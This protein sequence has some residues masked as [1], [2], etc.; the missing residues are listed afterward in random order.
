[1]LFAVSSVGLAELLVKAKSPV[2]VQGPTVLQ[3]PPTI[4]PAGP[5]AA[6]PGNQTVTQGGTS[7]GSSGGSTG[8]SSGGTAGGSGG[9]GGTSGGAGGTTGGSG[10]S[11]GGSGGTTGGTGGTSGGSGGTPQPPSGY[12]YLAAVS[13]V[14]GSSAYFN[15]PSGGSCILVDYNGT[16]RAF[17]A[18]CTHAGCVC[19]FT[20]STLYCPCHGANFSATNGAVINGP[21]NT[22]VAEYGIQIVNSNFYV[23]S[24]RIN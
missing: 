8:G 16:W 14:S 24:S 17:S 7:A 12:I 10:G 5:V 6:S 18:I 22:P 4:P 11:T 1:M 9:S 19:N 2:G 21:A 23:S 15:H 13:A 20:G 3:V